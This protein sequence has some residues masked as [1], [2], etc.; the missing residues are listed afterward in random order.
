M[1]VKSLSDASL[2]FLLGERAVV[3]RLEM[4]HCKES[5][6]L[7]FRALAFFQSELKG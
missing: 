5:Q 1:D 4:D 2:R 7:S 3:H 6:K